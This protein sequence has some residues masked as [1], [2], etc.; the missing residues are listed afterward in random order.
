M[1]RLAKVALHGVNGLTDERRYCAG[2]EAWY[3]NSEWER[4]HEDCLRLPVGD[5]DE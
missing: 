5:S 3:P 2:C 1:G 4:D